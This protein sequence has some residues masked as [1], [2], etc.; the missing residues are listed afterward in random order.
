MVAGPNS[1]H[2]IILGVN[3]LVL[4][5]AAGLAAIAIRQGGAHRT[6]TGGFDPAPQPAE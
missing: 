5:I 4:A 2:A 6:V 3:A 1:Y